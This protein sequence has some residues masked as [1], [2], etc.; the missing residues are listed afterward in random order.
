[1]ETLPLNLGGSVTERQNAVEVMPHILQGWATKGH[2]TVPLFV[3][4]FALGALTA[5][6]EVQLP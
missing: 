1:M 2:A 4:T 5:T 6:Y 3:E